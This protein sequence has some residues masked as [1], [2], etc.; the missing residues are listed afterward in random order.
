MPTRFHEPEELLVEGYHT[1]DYLY[2]T[3]KHLVAKALV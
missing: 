1:L 3:H 2:L